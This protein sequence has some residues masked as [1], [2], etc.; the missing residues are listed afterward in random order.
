MFRN[1]CERV[2]NGFK[3]SKK[4]WQSNHNYHISE[5]L[6]LAV[7]PEFQCISNNEFYMQASGYVKT[8]L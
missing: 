8:L 7:F 4:F 5:K 1:K 6:V 3:V 2:G